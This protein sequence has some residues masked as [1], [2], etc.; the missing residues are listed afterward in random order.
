MRHMVNV[1]KVVFDSNARKEI[2]SFPKDIKMEL[3]K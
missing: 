3:G 1:K 2:Q